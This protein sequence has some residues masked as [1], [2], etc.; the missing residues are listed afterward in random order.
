[1]AVAVAEI[2]YKQEMSLSRLFIDFSSKIHYF[3]IGRFPS[4]YPS[5]FLGTKLWFKISNNDI[6]RDYAY[7]QFNVIIIIVAYL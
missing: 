5:V 4:L 3:L 1:M 6:K 7:E 2:I